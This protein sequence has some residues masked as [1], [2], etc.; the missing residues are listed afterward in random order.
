M[1]PSVL[2]AS[3][4]MTAARCL[5]AVEPVV[6][7][8]AAPFLLFPTVQRGATLGALL[9]LVLVWVARWV[10]LDDPWPS[11]AINGALLLFAAMIPVGIW[12][13]AFPEITL[14]KLTGLILGLAGFRALVLFVHDRRTLGW[15]LAAFFGLGLAILAVGALGAGWTDKVPALGLLLQRLPRAFAD[16]PGAPD[17]GINPNQLAGAL[18]LFIPLA[19]ALVGFGWQE[20]RPGLAL[21]ALAG[22]GLLA[23]VLFLCQSRGGWLGGLVGLVA[24][25]FLRL[26][27]HSRRTRTLLIAG[28]IVVFAAGLVLLVFVAYVGP[29]RIGAAVFGFETSGEAA[30]RI[31]NV[32]L[33]GRLEIWS[34]ALSALHD[35]PITGIGLG[36]FR[37]VADLIYPLAVISPERDI[38]HAHNMFLQT[39]LDL[40]LPGLVA[41]LALLGLAVL[42]AGRIIRQDESSLSWVASGL[43]A[44][45]TGLHVYGLVDVMA[46][47]S[48]PGLAFWM[49]LGLIAALPKV[50]SCEQ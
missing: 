3:G 26:F 13:S 49:S 29:E 10:L 27:A 24:L 34:R 48:K 7:L 16:L 50:S 44:G 17:Q 20:R 42:L 21:L 11:T 43:L 18:Q 40:G 14:P 35:A 38:A 31:G 28:L 32:S 41:Y 36:A 37:R 12:A 6:V 2:E 46:L 1:Q 15:A 47:G 39:A 23:G 5:P 25:I 4:L 22:F 9:C 33:A 8:L 30:S 45:L 19:L